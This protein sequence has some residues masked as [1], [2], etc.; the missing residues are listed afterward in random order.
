[1][2]ITNGSS[3]LL[4]RH[5]RIQNNKKLIYLIIL[6]FYNRTNIKKKNKTN[7]ITIQSV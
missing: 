2:M 3:F 5:V 6:I 4:S 7:L 1:M